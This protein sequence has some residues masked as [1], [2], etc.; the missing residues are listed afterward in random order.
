MCLFYADIL[1]LYYGLQGGQ[2]YFSH[3][4]MS[5][6][7]ITSLGK[8]SPISSRWITTILRGLHVDAEQ[9]RFGSS[10]EAEAVYQLLDILVKL[11]IKNGNNFLADVIYQQSNDLFGKCN[12]LWTTL[13][14][15][16]QKSFLT[17]FQSSEDFITLITSTLSSGLGGNEEK[18]SMWSFLSEL[19]ASPTQ[20][21]SAILI[22]AGDRL[23]WN[24]ESKPVQSPILR[25]AL[26]S[27]SAEVDDYKC[28]AAVL[29]FLVQVFTFWPSLVIPCLDV[30]VDSTFIATLK[31]T[32]EQ[33]CRAPQEE[34]FE[35]V[36]RMYS[37]ALALQLMASTVF[38]LSMAGLSIQSVIDFLQKPDIFDSILNITGQRPSLHGNLQR[39]FQKKWKTDIS[40]FLKTPIATRQLGPTVEYDTGAMS[41]CL[42]DNLAWQSYAM[43]IEEAN[44]NFAYLDTKI[45]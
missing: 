5:A 39:N 2:T 41:R 29:N 43:E 15:T 17:Y 44:V 45:V 22:L 12:T 35:N 13:I 30:Y 26:T 28:H 34:S 42:G 9:Q 1:R 16:Q 3:L 38:I 14:K 36:W 31:N 32:V 8:D 33:E 21:V 40:V 4:Q 20:K 7:Y 25:I 11:D 19:I 37:A 23:D 6:E 24:S 27:L 10:E 18:A